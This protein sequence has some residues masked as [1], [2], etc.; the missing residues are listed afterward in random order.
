MPSKYRYHTYWLWLPLMVW[1][2][3]G[4]GLTQS[5]KK[6]TANAAHAIF[7]KKVDTF[8]LQLVA[9][10]AL[11]SDDADM[12][13]P[14]EVRV[15]PLRNSAAFD[16]ATY[17][18]LLKQSASALGNDLSGNPVTVRVMPG[19]SVTVEVPLAEDVQAVAIAA[20]FLHPDMQRNDWRAVI[21]RNEMDA[22]NP[23]VMELNNR[24]LQRQGNP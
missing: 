18:A 9:R 22:Y 15:W 7:Y 4:C 16:Q 5:V 21:P 3:S 8:H 6:G 1:L 17:S 12:A 14:V 20:F 10:A 19:H 24:T 13:S 23:T 11:N 2:L